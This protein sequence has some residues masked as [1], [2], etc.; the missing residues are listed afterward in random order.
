MEWKCVLL[1][2]SN[3]ITYSLQMITAKDKNTLGQGLL[4][5]LFSSLI[6]DYFG[7]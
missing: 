1:N 7:F 3:Q 5:T 4:L 2:K 6:S